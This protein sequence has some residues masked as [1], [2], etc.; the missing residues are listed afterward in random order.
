MKVAILMDI[1]AEL[2]FNVRTLKGFDTPFSSHHVAAIYDL[3]AEFAI[4]CMHYEIRCFTIS[5]N[6]TLDIISYNYS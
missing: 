2:A 6:D 4:C 1:I 3:N 5:I